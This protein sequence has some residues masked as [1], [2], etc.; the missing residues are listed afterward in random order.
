M[1]A[2]SAPARELAGLRSRVE[3]LEAENQN[4]RVALASRIVI[5][6][7]KGMLIERLELPAEDVFEL[8]RS[9]ARRARRPLHDVAAEILKTRVTPEYIDRE[10]ARLRSGNSRASAP[11]T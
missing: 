2:A 10:I 7:A 4:L 6:Q 3:E 8:L 11:R 1:S 9:A 5:E